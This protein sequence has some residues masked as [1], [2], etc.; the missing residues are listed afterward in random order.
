MKKV[1]VTGHTGF[2]GSYVINYLQQKKYHVIGI[3][4]NKLQNSNF[5]QFKI[6]IDKINE[7]KIS[8]KIF[9]VIHCAGITDVQYCHD[10]PDKYF[11]SNLSSTQKMLEFSRRK[12]CKFPGTLNRF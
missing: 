10:N 1:I 2:I 12:K 8:G 5:N 11:K 7:K 9:G 3:S 4:R 6:D